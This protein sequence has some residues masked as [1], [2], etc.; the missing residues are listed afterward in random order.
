MIVTP[1]YSQSCKNTYLAVV[2]LCAIR[3]GLLI[4][5]GCRVLRDSAY[6]LNW[7]FWFCFEI[8]AHSSRHDINSSLSQAI[9]DTGCS[10]VRDEVEA[11]AIILVLEAALREVRS[12]ECGI[13][14]S[15]R[16]DLAEA[17]SA[18]TPCCVPALLIVV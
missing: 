16:S 9:S 13:I 14:C 4:R 12:D 18:Y 17:T 15:H 8:W 3:N 6:R 5:S 1:G 2:V 7:N 10:G 11:P